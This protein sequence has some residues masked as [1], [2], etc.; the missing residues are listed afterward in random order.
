[1]A[2]ELENLQ[3]LEELE[4][5]QRLMSAAGLHLPTATSAPNALDNSGGMRG[6]M[7]R[8]ERIPGGQ[9][10]RPPDV[11]AVTNKPKPPSVAEP[12]VAT[13]K[14]ELEKTPGSVIVPCRARGM[15]MDHNFKVR[16]SSSC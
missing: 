4:R 2:S 8:D 12:P 13:D 3:R 1:L 9:M 10:P 11:M 5:R 16:W 14:E 15:P 7:L 6:A